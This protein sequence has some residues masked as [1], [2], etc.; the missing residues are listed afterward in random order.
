MNGQRALVTGGTGAIGPALVHHLAMQGYTVSSYS[1]R[2][3][4]T[5]RLI[6]DVEYIQGD[7]G[8]Q[9]KLARALQGIDIVFHLAALLHVEN[10]PPELAERYHAINVT[11]TE[12][13]A[14]Q[15][16]QAGVRRFVYFSTVKVYGIQ[17]R[18]PLSEEA[19]PN[20]KTMYAQTKF[21]GEQVVHSAGDLETVVLRLSA[22]YGPSLRGSW[23][24]MV[25]AIMKG[26]FVPIGTLQNQRSMT[27]VDDVARAAQFAA[28]HP[29]T[30]GQVFNV[31]GQETVTMHEILSAIYTVLDKPLPQVRIPG[32]IALSGIQF[33]NRAMA[34]MGKQSPL[35][36]EAIEQLVTDEVY[37]G[38]KLR[39]LGLETFT[40]LSQ[41][42]E[43]TIAG[44]MEP[45]S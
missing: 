3:P 26:W 27:Y 11:G 38:A 36:S 10:P 24:R 5:K 15:A 30:Y 31:V 33:M 34:L 19:V 13:V 40:P 14:R 4:D 12:N 44:L 21:R 20:P 16:V 42:W 43:Q 8:D 32:S 9:E 41:G 7:L 28:E 29:S 18:D 1:R 23:E 25:K 39:R 37:S 45:K 6:S 22:V 2:T 35:T 17:Q